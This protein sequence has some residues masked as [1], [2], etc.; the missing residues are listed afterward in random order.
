MM[1]ATVK[2]ESK[3]GFIFK[4]SG[5]HLSVETTGIVGGFGSDIVEAMSDAIERLHGQFFRDVT[6]VP[7]GRTI[8]R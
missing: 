8:S 7:D 2:T 4:Y 3:T 5:T 6:L 1:N